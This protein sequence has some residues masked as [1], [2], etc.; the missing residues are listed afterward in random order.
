MLRLS[1][2]SDQIGVS[3]IIG[4]HPPI[5]LWWPCPK[6]TPSRRPFWNFQP[7]DILPPPLRLPEP[8]VQCLPPG[9][10]VSLK[11]MCLLE[12]TNVCICGKH[13]SYGAML[14][15]RGARCSAGE[16]AQQGESS[17]IEAQDCGSR[18]SLVVQWLRLHTPN[19]YRGLRFELWL[20]NWNSTCHN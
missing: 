16:W 1:E 18:T 8:L 12:M 19:Q 14:E 3:P 4:L 11:E 20:G 7:R 5:L 17:Q 9:F 15:S 6:A 10:P 13:A 2:N